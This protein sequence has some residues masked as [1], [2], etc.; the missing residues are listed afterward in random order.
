MSI[1]LTELY[2]QYIYGITDQINCE[3]MR[4][5][6][7][8]LLF[9]TDGKAEIVSDKGNY[10]VNKGEIGLMRPLSEYSVSTVKGEYTLICFDIHTFDM[11]TA[12]ISAMYGAYSESDVITV[13]SDRTISEKA[14]LLTKIQGYH[15]QYAYLLMLLSEIANHKSISRVNEQLNEICACADRHSSEQLEAKNVAEQY[16]MSYPTFA[17]RFRDKFGRT[18]KEHI[19][20]VRIVKAK[21][22]LCTTDMDIN[23]VASET[24]Y[25]DSSHFIRSYRKYFGH[26]PKSERKM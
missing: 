8:V 13:F 19:G 7:A 12:Y 26:S 5:H 3:P 18:Y 4:R 14:E 2:K 1:T 16:G 20:Y 24:G 10:T 22:L 11:P 6:Y 17:K 23:A 15:S 21:T 25:F 9:V